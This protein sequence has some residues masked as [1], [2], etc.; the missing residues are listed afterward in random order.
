MNSDSTT[1]AATIH[2]VDRPRLLVITSTLPRFAGDPEPRFVL[3]LAR[4]L[5]VWFYVTILAPGDPAALE[6]EM[7]EGV[8]VVRYRYAPFRSWE[9]LAY[10]GGIMPRLRR[11]PWQWLQVP[12]LFSGLVKAIR[13][14]NRQERFDCIHCH[15]LVPQALAA[16]VALP[17][18]RRPPVVA[19][20][21][22]GDFHTLARGPKRA[23]LTYVLDRVNA[24]T[25]VSEP[26][27]Q[28][29]T[30]ELGR[31]CPAVISMGVDLELF[32]QECRD[33]SWPESVG[34][35]RPLIL[36]VGRLAEKK[37]V[38]HLLD[39][40]ANPALVGLDAHLAVV[41][42]GPLRLSL[43]K[44]ALTLG[45]HS[46]VKFLGAMTH[47][48]LPRYYASAEIV[49]VPSVVAADGDCEGLPTV[50]LE[51]MAS[52]TAVVATRVG[53][54]PQIIQDGTTGRLMRPG[55]PTRLADLL[56]TLL[57]DKDQRHRLAANALEFVQTLGWNNIGRAYADV[58]QD[59]IGQRNRSTKTLR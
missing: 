48:D 6:K 31:S 13:N 10:P 21:H 41:G 9:S 49:V 36:F 44:K 11:H 17:A 23:L 4:A 37:G 18:Q 52:G 40:M 47:R 15:W 58:I 29:V 42:D 5:Q 46:R 8:P 50:I 16:L 38:A 19:T 59:S 57:Q 43:E 20:S 3:D 26:L 1:R 25:V 22:G 54:I 24:V 39:A 7:F 56:K 34:L 30:K 55:D 12:L 14:L 33:E 2:S 35:K 32:R 53:G 45:L 28:Y 51:A 27:A